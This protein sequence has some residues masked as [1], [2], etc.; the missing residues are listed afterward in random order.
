MAMSTMDNTSAQL[1]I[2]LQLH[3]LNELEAAGTLD[4]SVIRLQ[5]QQLEIDSGFDAVTFEASRRLTLSIAK[6]VEDDSAF[7]T[8]LAPSR[9]IDRATFD[10]LVLLN[11]P[12]ST[13]SR[14]IESAPQLKCTEQPLVSTVGRMKRARSL[15]PEDGP[16]SV[17]SNSKELD[18]RSPNIAN[19]HAEHSPKRVRIEPVISG[20]HPSIFVTDSRIS[21]Q[22][23]QA[24]TA[25]ISSN[26]V[27]EETAPI[28]AIVTAPSTADCASCSEQLTT[29]KLVK[30][31]CEHYYC[32]ECFGQFVEASLQTHD[33]FPPKCC[34]I[35]IAF[36]TVVENVP[37]TVFSRYSA[38]QAEIKN[39]TALY[40][41]VRRCGVKIE[42]D[43][44]EG[45]RATC[46]ACWRD[47]CTLCRGEFPRDI[48]GKKQSHVCK[49][50]KAREQVL[51]LAKQE[52]WQTCYQC[53]NL[54]ALNTG[55][56][57]MT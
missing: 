12:P 50:D 8:Q 35:P 23:P 22:D 33:G 28:T 31:S 54:V 9:Q 5:R 47:T 46:I 11:H 24:C 30:A 13:S 36:I 57:H 15:T 21:S 3:D 7:L 14:L 48:N 29:D 42:N 45:V 40:C 39:A 17:S 49:K 53:G 55:C 18:L 52:G 26:Q 44:I 2:A 16:S 38:R 41:G 32:K 25:N 4:V 19:S 56:H 51:A 43:R 1:A 34:K 27:I 6:A 10:R 20:Q 37:A